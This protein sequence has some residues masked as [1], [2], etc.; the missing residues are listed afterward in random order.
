MVGDRWAMAEYRAYRVGL[1]GHFIGYEPLVCV[2]DA[3]AT[4]KARRLVDGYDIELWSGERFVVRLG[5]K[6]DQK[7]N[8]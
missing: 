7:T 1:D 3:E 5:R 4:A 2:N 8:G 6:Q